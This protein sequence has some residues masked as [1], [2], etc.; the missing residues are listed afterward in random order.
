MRYGGMNSTKQ[1]QGRRLSKRESSKLVDQTNQNFI[2]IAEDP[3]FP[4]QKES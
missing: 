1:N 4:A 3:T 2:M